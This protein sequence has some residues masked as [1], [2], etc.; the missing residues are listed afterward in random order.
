[1]RRLSTSSQTSAISAPAAAAR[2]TTPGASSKADTLQKLTPH[3]QRRVR[4]LVVVGLLFAG[5]GADDDRD[6]DRRVQR[7][8]LVERQRDRDLLAL[9][10]PRDGLVEGQRR[11][12]GGP[13]DG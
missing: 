2:A 10:R 1:M 8:R 6:V 5:N 7:R 12:A 13:R 11:P 9:G 3:E 4:R